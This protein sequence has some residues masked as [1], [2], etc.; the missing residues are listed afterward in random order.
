MTDLAIRIDNLSMRYRLGQRE[1]YKTMR[2]ALLEVN[3][4]MAQ[5][6]PIMRNTSKFAALDKGYAIP[7]EALK[8]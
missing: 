6:L 8:I 5:R 3:T 2:D 7:V 1:P 4:T